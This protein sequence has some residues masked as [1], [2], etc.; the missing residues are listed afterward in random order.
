MPV[1]GPFGPQAAVMIEQ[2]YMGAL[3]SHA[4]LLRGTNREGDQLA[5]TSAPSLF[6]RCAL[7]NPH[8]AVA[9]DIVSR[10]RHDLIR[11]SWSGMYETNSQPDA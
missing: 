10:I 1:E 5:A 2:T 11:K 4:E 3:T 7:D 9:Y 6:D 8:I